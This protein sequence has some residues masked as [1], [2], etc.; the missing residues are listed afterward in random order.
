MRS[1]SPEVLDLLQHLPAATGSHAKGQQSAR[2]ALR[3]L[4]SVLQQWAGTGGGLLVA[5]IGVHY[6]NARDMMATMHGGERIIFTNSNPV[7][8]REWLTHLFA[9]FSIADHYAQQVTTS[10]NATRDDSLLIPETIPSL[11]LLDEP[12]D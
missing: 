11:S 10:N 9:L 8:R 6:N 7:T 1:E 2:E 5:S 4:R 3:R 12:T